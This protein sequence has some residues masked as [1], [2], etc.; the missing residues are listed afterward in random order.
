MS[1]SNPNPTTTLEAVNILLEA[2]GEAPINNLSTDTVVDAVIAKN[3]LE[4][5]LKDVQ[6]EGWHF[7]T[8]IAYPLTRE[9]NGEITVPANCVSVDA[10]RTHHPALDVT[11][12]GTRLYNRTDH[13]YEFTSTV[14]VDMIVLLAFEEMPEAGRRYVTTKAARVFQDRMVG[15]GDL[16][17][18]TATDEAR[19]RSTLVATETDNADHMIFNSTDQIALLI[20]R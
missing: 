16:H 2:I 13:T 9:L 7:N 11:Q 20:R 5:V 4:E 10:N 12:R 8:E 3:V 18:F 17:T 6:T 1:L 15:S 14:Y 19:A